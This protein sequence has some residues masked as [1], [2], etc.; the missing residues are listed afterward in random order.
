MPGTG[1]LYD[2]PNPTVSG[3]NISVDRYLSDPLR[4]YR[5]LRTLVQQRLIGDRLL[6]GR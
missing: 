2:F 6:T 1:T 4:V 3:Q 5:A